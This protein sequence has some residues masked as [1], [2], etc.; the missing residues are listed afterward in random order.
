MGKRD[1][2]KDLEWALSKKE[3]PVVLVHALKRAI[4]AEAQLADYKQML[5]SSQENAGMAID[6]AKYWQSLNR[7]LVEALGEANEVIQR[8]WHT[9]ILRH[10]EYL[11]YQNNVEVLTKAKEVMDGE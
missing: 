8:L 11:L 5:F 1:L 2:Q 4:K 10:E 9:N 7:E 6:T 3:F